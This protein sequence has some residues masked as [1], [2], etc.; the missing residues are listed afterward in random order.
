MTTTSSYRSTTPPNKGASRGRTS[1]GSAPSPRRPRTRGLRGPAGLAGA[2][3]LV[4]AVLA[5]AGWLVGFSPVLA[6][7]RV[8]VT[9]AVASPLRLFERRLPFHWASPWPDRT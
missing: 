2:L 5:G 8:E 9:G 6:V 3:V 7:E 1:G 4:L